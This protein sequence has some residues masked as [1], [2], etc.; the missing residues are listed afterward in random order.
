MSTDSLAESSRPQDREM[1]LTAHLGEMRTRVMWSVATWIVA[2]IGAWFATP[3]IIATMRRPLGNTQLVFT[4]PT[5][6]FMVYLKTAVLFGFFAAL[7][8]ILYQVAAFVSPG[9]E[10]HEKRWI[11]RIVPAALL[12]FVSGV[13]F[14]YFAVLPVTLSFFIS[15]QSDDIRAMLTISE[16]IG[17]I[18]MMLIVCG[19]IFQTPIVI[20]VLAAI[21]LVDAPKLRASRRYA[22]LLIFIIAAIVTPTPD[23]FTQ[24]VVAAPML[25]LYE[26]SI[27]LVAAMHR[28]RMT[29]APAESGSDEA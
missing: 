2:A 4:K 19:L 12:L 26:L 16:Y 20:L 25:V 3:W 21:G 6:A 27:W 15:F 23:A 10:D 13:L 9:L 11:R 24:G 28:G 14:G 7:P 8:V 1:P 17:F 22:I 18:T 5:E 29:E